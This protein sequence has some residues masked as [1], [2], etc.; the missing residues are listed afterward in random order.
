MKNHRDQIQRLFLEGGIT[1]AE[2][3][4][5]TESLNNM[6]QNLDQHHEV[7]AFCMSNVPGFE[8]VKVIIEVFRMDDNLGRYTTISQ[9]ECRQIPWG[10]VEIP[11]IQ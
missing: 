8:R 2:V 11:R 1:Q 6:L 9:V 3:A 4:Q 7:V 10:R 5:K